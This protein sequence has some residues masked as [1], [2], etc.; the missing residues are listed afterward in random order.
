MFATNYICV[1]QDFII[2]VIDKKAISYYNVYRAVNQEKLND[3]L[4]LISYK[5]K[6][7]EFKTINLKVNKQYKVTT[8]SFSHVRYSKETYLFL[9][10]GV[11]IV[12][13]VQISKK[14][15]FPILILDYECL[16]KG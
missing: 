1:A 6:D 16:K 2:K 15:E 5:K 11:S 8:R 4:I 13:S 12:D 3:T 10:P 14:G 7:K 9:P